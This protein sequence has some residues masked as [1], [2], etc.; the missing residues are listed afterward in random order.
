MTTRK[1]S[2]PKTR[3]Q[4]AADAV[5][6][7]AEQAAQIQ[8][9]MPTNV[10]AA[11][12]RVQADIGGI[13][14][15][16]PDNHDGEGGGLK[17]AFRGI[18]QVT[19]AAQPLFGKYGVVIVPTLETHVVDEIMVNGRPWTDT[20]VTVIWNIYGP[21]D[22]SLAARTVGLGRD[23]SDK[24]YA[25]AMTQA[26][27]NLVL[28][29]LAIGDPADDTD[30]HTHERDAAPAPLN[31]EDQRAVDETR[32]LLDRLKKIGTERPDQAAEIKTFAASQ[33]KMMNWSGLVEDD[34]WRVALTHFLDGLAAEPEPQEDPTVEPDPTDGEVPTT[35]LEDDPELIEGDPE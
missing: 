5:K 9:E 13:A 20:T 33:S 10:V 15:K 6:E 1:P 19:A 28:R 2:E 34:P 31:E 29:M 14:K 12:A 22:T 11:L 7:V 16:R 24:G 25:K 30:G 35:D 4:L 21:G 26:Y 32:A 18:D 8:Q 27:K 17:Y 23:N 3:E